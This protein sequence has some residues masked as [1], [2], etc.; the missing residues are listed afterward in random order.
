ES[1]LVSGG[2]GKGLLVIDYITGRAAAQKSFG[3]TH[4]TA[5][6]LGAA[7][8]ISQVDSTV[9]F[10]TV[11]EELERVYVSNDAPSKMLDAGREATYAYIYSGLSEEPKSVRTNG[12]CN[13]VN[14]L[15]KVYRLDYVARKRK[16]SIVQTPVGKRPITNQRVPGHIALPKDIESSH[17]L[18]KGL[19]AFH[20]EANIFL[21]SPW[22]TESSSRIRDPFD[23]R[24][25]FANKEACLCQHKDKGYKG[26]RPTRFQVF[27]LLHQDTQTFLSYIMFKWILSENMGK[28]SWRLR[29]SSCHCQSMES[30]WWR[31]GF[32]QSYKVVLVGLLQVICDWRKKLDEVM[33]GRA[34][35][36]NKGFGVE[37]K[38]KLIKN[39]GRDEDGNP[40]YGPMTPSFLDIED[41]MEM[42]LGSE[43]HGVYR[44]TEGDGLRHTKF[45][46]ITP[47]GRKFTKG[48][49]TKETIRKLSGK[50][51]SDDI[52]ATYDATNELPIPPLQAP[53]ASATVVPPVLSLFYSRDFF[54]L[55]GISP[56]KD[57]GIPIKSSILVSPSSSVGS[58]S[59]VRSIT[60]PLDY[61]FDEFIYAELDNSLWIISRPLESKPVPEEPNESDA[62]LWK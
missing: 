47:S 18:T 42:A 51:T 4:Y 48:F 53:I 17:A 32:G 46:V 50:F 22:L 44:K 11:N 9:L 5:E 16:R 15:P 29:P 57:A 20:L 30:D 23:Q 19:A 38:E 25:V 8:G 12:K 60:P 31:I 37:E 34:R 6:S 26:L 13:S 36:E 1:S 21:Q 3:S 7:I 39:V 43:R 35:L 14:F 49:E 10:P 62:H 58:S 33:M 27:V 52:L 55:E 41:E 56:P 45:E 2:K 40:K 61:L 59:P 24:R 54:P 28:N